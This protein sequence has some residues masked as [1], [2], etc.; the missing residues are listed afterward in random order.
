MK[1]IYKIERGFYNCG[2][3]HCFIADYEEELPNYCP[4]CGEK[5]DKNN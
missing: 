3:C 5:V 4:N 2:K 1:P